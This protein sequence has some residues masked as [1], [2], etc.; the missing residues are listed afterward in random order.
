VI[1]LQ[2]HY[3]NRWH[4]RQS[5]DKHSSHRRKKPTRWVGY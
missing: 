2:E 4:Q 5:H 3:K 1:Y